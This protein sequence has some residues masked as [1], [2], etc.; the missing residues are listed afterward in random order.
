MT[1]TLKVLVVDDSPTELT[2]MTEPFLSNG[3]EVITATN[4]EEALQKAESEN[5]SLIVLDVVMPKLNGFQV[6]KHI[7]TSRKLKDTPVILLTTKDQESD[8]FFGIKQGANAYMTK[9]FTGEDLMATVN[10]LL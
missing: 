2:L 6:C 8:K 1:A 5:P 9:P 3:Y 4:G 10:K 7:K